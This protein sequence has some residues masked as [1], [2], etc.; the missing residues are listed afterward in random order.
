MTK[1]MNKN[2]LRGGVEAVPPE[3]DLIPTPSLQEKFRGVLA[4]CKTLSSYVQKIFAAVLTLQY[5]IVN[6]E[7]RK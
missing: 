4:L 7:M 2:T 6:E 3:A 1:E 5:E